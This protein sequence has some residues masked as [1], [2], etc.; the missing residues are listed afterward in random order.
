M[1]F[2]TALLIGFVWYQVIAHIGISLGLHR[3]WAHRAFKAG[4]V[5]EVVSLYMSILAG[6]RSP[7]GWI[8]AHRMHHHYSDTELDPHSP[9]TKGFW[10]VFFSL[11]S[12]PSISPKYSKDLFENPRMRFFHVHWKVIWAASAFLIAVLFGPY[13][14]LSFIVMPAILAPIGFGLVNAVTHKN[15]TVNNVPWINILVAGEGYH[16]GH[17]DGST[18]RYHKYDHT[19]WALE[20]LIKIGVF[21]TNGKQ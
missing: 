4:P 8:A 11:W 15:N 5:F 20:N 6:A 21:N 17:H 9:N 14:F 12:I 19:G 3:Y 16:K 7:I 13:M 18:V 2:L 10:T 1:D